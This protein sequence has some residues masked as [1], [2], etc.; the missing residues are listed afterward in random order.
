M[1]ETMKD[2]ASPG[3]GG[4]MSR[5]RKRE[6]VLRLLRG[7]DLETVS[8]SLGVTVAT[9]SAWL[10]AFLTAGEARCCWSV[11]CW[12]PKSPC[13]RVTAFSSQE[14]EAMSRTISPSS[15]KPY[16]LARVCRIWRVARASVY[17]HRKP[18]PDR[19]R[20]CRSDHCPIRCSPPRSV[21]SWPPVRSMAKGTGKS[22]PACA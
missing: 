22:G 19:Q 14:V 13:W 20:R 16:D 8:R 6:A 2:A 9:L 1:A 21:P 17:R 7:E 12:R 4:R 10:D 5:Q 18:Q 11:N 15:R 3:R